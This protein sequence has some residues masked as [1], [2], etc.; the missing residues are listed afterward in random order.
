MSLTELKEFSTKVYSRGR[1]LS[2]ELTTG[3]DGSGVLMST[4]HYTYIVHVYVYMVV[5]GVAHV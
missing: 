3:M 2:H 5:G 4:L 1:K